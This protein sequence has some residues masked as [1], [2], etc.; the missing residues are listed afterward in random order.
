MMMSTTAATAIPMPALA[1]V[2]RPPEDDGITPES[3]GEEVPLL[4]GA[5]LMELVV[6][7]ADEVVEARL[8][9]ALLVPVPV[10][11]VLDDVVEPECVETIAPRPFRTMPRSSAQHFGSLSQQKLPSEHST[12]RGRKPVPG[13]ICF[14]HESIHH[15]GICIRD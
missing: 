8:F 10:A 4:V 9:S 3:F 11:D 15:S 12:A 7:L 14:H 1:P 6:G 5:E 13:S 2:D